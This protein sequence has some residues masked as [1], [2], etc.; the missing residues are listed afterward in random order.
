MSSL[1]LLV[2]KHNVWFPDLVRRQSEHADPSIVRLIPLKLVVIPHL[3]SRQLVG[4]TTQITT[5]FL[6]SCLVGVVRG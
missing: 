6:V 3:Q 2:E 4:R 1:Y 5:L